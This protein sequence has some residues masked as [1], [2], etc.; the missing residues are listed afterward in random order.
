ML[1]ALTRLFPLLLLLSV[2]RCS[3]RPATDLPHRQTLRSNMVTTRTKRHTKL[4]WLA[5]AVVV[6]AC[7]HGAAGQVDTTAGESP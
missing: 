6:L 3:Y 2:S 5:A 4:E 7:V 1:L